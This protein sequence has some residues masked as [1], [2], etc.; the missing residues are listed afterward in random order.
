MCLS[1]FEPRPFNDALLTTPLYDALQWRPFNDAVPRQLF[2]YRLST[3]WMGRNLP[4]T[5]FYISATVFLIPPVEMAPE[6]RPTKEMLVKNPVKRSRRDEYYPR[7]RRVPFRVFDQSENK[8]VK[9]ECLL[10]E[11]LAGICYCIF[12]WGVNYFN[13]R[14]DYGWKMIEWSFEE[15]KKL[16]YPMTLEIFTAVFQ[17]SQYQCGH[18]SWLQ[19]FASHERRQRE[20]SGQDR[21]RFFTNKYQ[22]SHGFGRPQANYYKTKIPKEL[23]FGQGEPPPTKRPS[24]FYTSLADRGNQ[25]RRKSNFLMEESSRSPRRIFTGTCP[26]GVEPPEERKK[27]KV[28][29]GAGTQSLESDESMNSENEIMDPSCNKNPCPKCCVPPEKN[30]TFQ[31]LF[32]FKKTRAAYMDFRVCIS[33]LHLTFG[34]LMLH[35]RW[36]V[37][38]LTS[39]SLTNSNIIPWSLMWYMRYI[40]IY[41]RKTNW[42]SRFRRN[43]PSLTQKIGFPLLWI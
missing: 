6:K 1:T 24:I 13:K 16:G 14:I 42:Y 10:S 35:I 38:V 9:M 19:A 32:G 22:E 4:A 33:C 31:E 23:R 26:K 8:M 12:D 25:I 37:R 5:Y 41:Y 15:A 2:H 30:L 7:N 34:R 17:V 29:P 36:D 27:W 20:T 21:M 3:Q 40:F 28:T 43:F 11:E 18:K 39:T